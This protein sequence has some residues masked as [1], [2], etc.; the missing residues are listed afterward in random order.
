MIDVN[1]PVSAEI[2][3]LARRLAERFIG[4]VGPVLSETERGIA[5]NTTYLICREELEAAPSR[6]RER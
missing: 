1:K 3:E 6:P 4:V 5:L 2:H